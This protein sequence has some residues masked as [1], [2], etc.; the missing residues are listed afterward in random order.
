MLLICTCRVNMA[1]R[2][3]PQDAWKRRSYSAY[4]ASY[5]PLARTVWA[6]FV[7]V[8]DADAPAG[9]VLKSSK[10]PH[11]KAGGRAGGDKPD[12][13]RTVLSEICL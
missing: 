2:R 7:A 9:L 13:T 5:V 1:R 12:P 3:E 11:Q 8:F 10:Q 4:R 6:Q